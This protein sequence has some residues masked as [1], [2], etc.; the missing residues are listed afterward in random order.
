MRKIDTV[1][2]IS[3]M[4]G[5][6]GEGGRWDEFD[7]ASEAFHEMVEEQKENLKGVLEEESMQLN[8]VRVQ[9]TGL[10]TPCLYAGQHHTE[11]LYAG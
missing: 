1:E 6:D 2:A 7:V 5:L 11:E 8:Q 4:S 9:S 3:K 10:G